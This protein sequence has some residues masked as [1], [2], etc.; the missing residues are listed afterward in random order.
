MICMVDTKT[1]VQEVNPMTTGELLR[2]LRKDNKYTLQTVADA[3]GCSPSYLHR[4]ER[5]NR[6][7][8]SVKMASELS[9]FYD[10]DLSLLIGVDSGVSNA[11]DM[12]DLK[13][14]LSEELNLA[15]EKIKEGI[16]ELERDPNASKKKFVEVQKSLLYMKSLI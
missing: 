16:L 15:T 6:K 10:I 9:R 4:L 5:S 3:V 7:N 11:S 12:L 1:I 8:P 13:E 2:R 14:S